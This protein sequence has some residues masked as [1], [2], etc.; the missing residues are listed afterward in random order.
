MWLMLV[1]SAQN[2]M[3]VE[4]L[5][6]KVDMAGELLQ[7]DE[8]KTIEV[9][10]ETFATDEK[11][12][13][14]VV[15][16]GTSMLDETVATNQLAREKTADGLHDQDTNGAEVSNR[17]G[18]V[19]WID[20]A[21]VTGALSSRTCASDRWSPG[22]KVKEYVLGTCLAQGAFG[23]VWTLQ[24]YDDVVIKVP[25]GSA[26][27]LNI[28]KESTFSEECFFGKVA[29][30]KDPEHFVDCLDHGTV[31]LGDYT[32]WQR[33][34]GDEVQKCMNSDTKE[35]FEHVF[36]TLDSV[37]THVAQLVHMFDVLQKPGIIPGSG[38]GVRQWHNDPHARNLLVSDTTFKLIDYGLQYQCCHDQ[39]CGKAMSGF[40]DV[41]L[42]PCGESEQGF[43]QM[44]AHYV[45]SAAFFMLNIVFEHLP[46]ALFKPGPAL[47]DDSLHTFLEELN[48]AE[49]FVQSAV[50][51]QYVTR[52]MYKGQWTLQHLQ[53]LRVLLSALLE[54][55]TFENGALMLKGNLT[56]DLVAFDSQWP[57]FTDLVERA[58]RNCH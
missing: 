13:E 49:G 11:A 15:E 47:R 30:Q 10:E 50:Y 16:T 33:V 28:S 4:A 36:P 9:A 20:G 45:H 19:H 32:V 42:K 31:T 57:R 34:E 52:T 51:G 41:E 46:M 6:K 17:A 58:W 23:Q 14:E 24:S 40:E 53:F 27:P 12:I 22:D 25:W 5:R 37:V 1:L 55:N 43:L 7:T 2:Q 44:Y 3:E 8:E 35:E 38:F 48:S 26:R 39:D 21:Q 29:A 18:H 54:V 56:S